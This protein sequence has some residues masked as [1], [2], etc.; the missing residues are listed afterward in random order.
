MNN[1]SNDHSSI[2]DAIAEQEAELK[3][4]LA[5]VMKEPLDPVVQCVESIDRRLGGVERQ[6]QETLDIHIPTLNRALKAQ[7]D[8]TRKRFECLRDDIGADI[9]EH[10]SSKLALLTQDL[11]LLRDEQGRSREA[12][13]QLSHDHAMHGQAIGA[14]VSQCDAA[15][16][17]ALVRID[18]LSFQAKTA[19]ERSSEAVNALDAGFKVTGAALELQ[20]TQLEQSGARLVDDLRR[21][22][23][24]NEVLA[25]DLE[26]LRLEHERSHEVTIKLHDEHA[27]RAQA[28]N[29][30]LGQCD[31]ALKETLVRVDAAGSQ[32][33][34]AVDNAGQVLRT[35]DA[36]FKNN[37]AVLEHQGVQLER[38][39]ARIADELCRRAD[40]TDSLALQATQKVES[41]GV[42]LEQHLQLMQRRV[43]L[44]T[45]VAGVSLAGMI[46]LVIKVQM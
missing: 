41:F 36:G 43:F 9:A 23:E 10:V 34:V 13:T 19:A 35:L 26:L 33:K 14:A 30:L 11:E 38:C 25:R 18:A 15:L 4:L 39:S 29:E 17:E 12:L 1:F 46:A 7:S 2:E 3:Q 22:T 37:G 16:K 40:N 21:G 6:C 5:R 28:Q 8:E 45:V 27:A 24:M 42:V 31:V 44:L 20:R 32:V